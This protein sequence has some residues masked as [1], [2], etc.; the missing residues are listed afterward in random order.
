MLEARHQQQVKDT[1]IEETD[2]VSVIRSL[3]VVN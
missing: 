2:D 3:L 1:G